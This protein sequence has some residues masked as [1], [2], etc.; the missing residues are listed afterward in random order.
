MC[1]WQ[2]NGK[3][4]QIQWSKR[5]QVTDRVIK[6]NTNWNAASGTDMEQLVAQTL[7]GI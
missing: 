1:S 7:L 3:F 6:K 4:N 2:D 5:Q